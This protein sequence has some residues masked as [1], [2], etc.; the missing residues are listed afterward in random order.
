MGS[1]K[2]SM[3][4]FAINQAL[5]Y[6]EGGPEENIPKLMEF[7]DRFTPKNWYVPQRA[8]VRTA[9]GTKNNWYQLILRLYELDPGVR[10]ALFQNLLFNASLKGSAIQDEAVAREGCNI[11]WAILLDPTS[12][13]NMHCTGC[14]AAEYGN[15]LNLSLETIDSIIRQGKELG[16]YMYIYTGGEPLVRKADLIKICEMHPDCEFLAFTNGTLIDEAFCEEMLRVKNFVPALSLE[17]FE[18]A[19]DSRRGQ[20]V[21]KTVHNAMALMKSYKLPFGISTCYTSRNIDDVS[22]EEFFDQMIEAG[23]LFVWFFHYMPVG[24]DAAVELLPKPEQRMKMYN[25]IRSFRETKP[26]FS[27]DFQ[28]DAEYVGGCIAGG[29]RYLHINAKGDVEPCVFIHY[30]NVNIHDVSLLEALKSPLFMAYHNGQP[31]N[32]N[33]LRPCPMLENPELLPRMVTD[34]GAVNTDYQS[35]ESAEHLCAK[36]APYAENWTPVA[37]QAWGEGQHHKSRMVN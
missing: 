19:N 7:V 12:A 8:A 1:V 24:N 6:I 27:M 34:A 36:T 3:Q 25:A 31:F 21:Y 29:R 20:G 23:A 4:N 26:I 32:D 35:P 2:E 28:N 14:W 15:Q 5:R 16:T 22:S 17:G 9:I 10:K 33:M 30:S 13:C 37:E 18:D 11:P